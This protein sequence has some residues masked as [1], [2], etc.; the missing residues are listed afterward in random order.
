MKIT[1]LLPGYTW[2]PSGGVR[3]VYE[4]ANRLVARGHQVS[5][6]HPRR[7]KYPTS[8][9]EGESSYYRL[10]RKLKNVVELFHRPTVDWQAIDPNVRS[11]YV[12]I[13]DATHIPDG[14]AV[15]ATGWQTARSVLELPKSK[16]KRFYLIQGYETFKGPKDLV[17]EA[18]RAPLRKIAVSRWLVDVGEQLGVRDITRVPNAVN[19]ERYR[20]LQPI[21]GRYPRVAMAFS[22]EAIKGAADGIHALTLV[23]RR[24]PDLKVVMFGLTNLRPSIPR[25]ID[26][27]SNPA[28][29]FIVREIYNNSSIFL[30]SSWAEGY[31]LP[32]AEAAACGCAV[33]S[34]DNGGIREYIEHGATGLL[35]SPRSPELLAENLCLL[36]ERD[37][38]R[39]RLATAAN[40]AVMQLDWEQSTDL[41]ERF[42]Q[43]AV[44]D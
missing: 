27:Y 35:S 6:I 22:K 18:L 13:V 7:F 41:L 21:E 2:G 19:H 29:E 1:F 44:V 39:C 34:T 5:V 40:K 33:V 23:R 37:E 30:C 25:W 42:L 16:G 4:Y 15:L 17:D 9:R 36:L 38:L 43:K 28:Q 31:S 10:R 26:Y 12:P 3:V 8:P 14:D 32:P 24:H 20:L 11:L